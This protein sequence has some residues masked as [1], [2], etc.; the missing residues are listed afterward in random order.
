MKLI[1]TNTNWADEMD[2]W[3]FEI[4]PNNALYEI[5]LIAINEALKYE[6]NIEIYVGTN[7]E[8]YFN[9]D[10][11]RDFIIK[12]I[13]QEDVDTLIK[14]FGSHTKGFSLFDR[15]V[16]TS[17]DILEEH[18]LEKSKEFSKIIYDE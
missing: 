6:D 4:V 10:F 5:Q 18:D 14:L 8:I 7:E 9:K 2:I 12:D 1:V 16:E 11:L 3:G 13:T 15:L 17:L